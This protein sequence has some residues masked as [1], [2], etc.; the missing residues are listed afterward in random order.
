MMVVGGHEVVGAIAMGY[1][2][3]LVMFDIVKAMF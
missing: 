3:A 1:V 2:F